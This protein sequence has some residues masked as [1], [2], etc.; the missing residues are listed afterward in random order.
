[1]SKASSEGLTP[2]GE[3]KARGRT[4]TLRLKV[5]ADA[6]EAAKRQAVCRLE[7]R[8]AD[9]VTQTLRLAAKPEGGL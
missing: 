3:K 9:I 5:P 6:W 8:L 1:M 2:L 7:T 4:V